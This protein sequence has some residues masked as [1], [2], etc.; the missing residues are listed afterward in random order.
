[1][2]I[3][4]LQENTNNLL[5]RKELK[6]KIFSEGPTPKKEAIYSEIAKKYKTKETHIDIKTIQQ[7]NGAQFS[8][9]SINIYK[10]PIRE[11]KKEAEKKEEPN[12]EKE[13]VKEIKEETKENKPEEKQDNTE[14]KKETDETKNGE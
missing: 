13:P 2:E 6:L 9:C 7:Q 12:E 1:M 3:E 5:D 4:T 8:I 14:Q 10:K 11:E